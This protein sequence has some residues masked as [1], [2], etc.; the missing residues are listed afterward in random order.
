MDALFLS[1]NHFLNGKIRPYD[2]LLLA[3]SGGPD[4]TCL[5]H[6]LLK[7]QKTI[8]FELEL[9]HVNHNMRSE[10]HEE[11]KE[12]QKQAKA[13]GL[14]L[15][16][17]ELTNSPKHNLEAFYRSERLQF[18][19]EL[20]SKN[21]YRALVL[22]HHQGDLEETVLKRFFE[23][24]SLDLIYGMKKESFR[25]HL[26]IWRPFLE[27]QKKDLIDALDQMGISYFVDQTNKDPK[28][29]RG[30]M[31]THLFEEIE[32]GFGKSIRSNLAYHAKGSEELESY[33]ERQTQN[34]VEVL[35]GPLGLY[36][37]L[38][39]IEEPLELRYRIK[40]ELSK[41]GLH[42]SRDQMKTIVEMILD[43]K[44]GTFYSQVSQK[45]IYVEQ[46]SLFS[47]NEG[48]AHLKRVPIQ[49]KQS[50]YRL[51]PWKVELK[52]GSLPDVKLGWKN[53]FS[54][55]PQFILPMP[56]SDSFFELIAP[57]TC[58]PLTFYFGKKL[59]KWWIDHKVPHFLRPLTPLLMD[60]KGVWGDFLT[61]KVPY[62]V[63][64]TQQYLEMSYEIS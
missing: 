31:R 64:K 43:N 7:V 51:G 53:L 11:A 30:R 41:R 62:E 49:K 33:L 5:L 35:E 26:A 48:L 40:K 12:V 27:V 60:K 34:K 45:A 44:Q 61:N 42:F 1:L 63:D 4:S 10:S 16:I 29:L 3:F 54:Q 46:K 14:K 8:P 28:Y 36:I 32:R 9:A 24:T 55:N 56:Q 50:I 57:Q 15:H 59:K 25:N 23:G 13:L 37:D 58:E 21:A 52:D 19:D 47:L 18:F 38:S 6:Y 2:K 22:A 20:H 17:K 39:Q